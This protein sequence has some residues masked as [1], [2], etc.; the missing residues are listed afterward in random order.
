MCSRGYSQELCSS[1]W[2]FLGHGLTPCG[3]GHLDEAGDAAYG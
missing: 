3:R 1:E 2:L